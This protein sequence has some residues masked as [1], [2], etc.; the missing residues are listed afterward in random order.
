MKHSF[1][2]SSFLEEISSLSHSI[3]FLYFFALITEE[4]LFFLAI[5]W[6]STFKWVYLSFLLCLSLL[7]FAQVFVRP[8]QTTILPFCIYFSWGWSWSLPPIQCPLSTVL[9]ALCLSDRIPWIYLSLSPYNSKGFDLVIPEY[10]SGFPYFLQFKSEF[11]NKEFMMWA[12]VSSQSCF[13]WHY[14]EST[15]KISLSSSLSKRFI[16]P[17]MILFQEEHTNIY[18]QN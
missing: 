16:I 7:F 11:C 12:T 5:L 8:P 17:L 10:S 9:Q 1:D 2:L 6:N 14:K 3:V 15:I 18:F 4:G 13:C